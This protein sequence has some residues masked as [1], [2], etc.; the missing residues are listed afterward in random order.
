MINIDKL[1]GESI[2]EK[3]ERKVKAFRLVK[4][5][6]VNAEKVDGKAITEAKQVKIIQHMIKDCKA[7]ADT[8]KRA[9]RSEMAADELSE[10]A[11]IETLLPKLPSK[12]EIIAFV[13]KVAAENF[14]KGHTF[15]MAD[16]K[17]IKPLVLKEYPLAN[18]GDIASAVKALVSK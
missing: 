9:G 4:A 8:Y 5:E 10:A 11:I 2:K 14:D 15:S 17:I 6:F 18:G 3:N 7:D 16:M 1:I 12:D 13:G